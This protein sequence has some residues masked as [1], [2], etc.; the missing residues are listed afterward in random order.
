V[1]SADHGGVL[2]LV[3][4]NLTTGRQNTIIIATKPSPATSNWPPGISSLTR[5]S[6]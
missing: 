5:G 4:R 1:I 6:R 2:E 3:A